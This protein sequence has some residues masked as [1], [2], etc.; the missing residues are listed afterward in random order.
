MTIKLSTANGDHLKIKCSCGKET[1]LS[2][3]NLIA[4]VGPDVTTHEVRQRAKCEHCGAIGDNTYQV[5]N[6]HS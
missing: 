2:I 1:S 3:A 4:V 5:I 6:K